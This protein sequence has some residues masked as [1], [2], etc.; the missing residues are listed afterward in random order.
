MSVDVELSEC[1]RCGICV[2]T[3]SVVFHYGP[4]EMVMVREIEGALPDC[5]EDAVRNCPA[6]CIRIVTT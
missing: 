2:E 1:I 6:D 3:C 4:G 5:V